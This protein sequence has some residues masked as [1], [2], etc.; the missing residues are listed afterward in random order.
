MAKFMNAELCGIRDALT[1]GHC[2]CTFK[3]SDSQAWKVKYEKKTVY[4]SDACRHAAMR[5]LHS[6]PLPN[7]GPC[8]TC[9]KPFFSRLNKKFCS[10]DCYIKSPQFKELAHSAKP[11]TA[12]AR[13]RG[14]QKLLKGGMVYC[15]ECGVEFYGKRSDSRKF[16]SSICYWSFM[17]KRFDRWIANPEGVALPQCY[18]E[19][20][21][22]E[23]LACLVEGCKWFGHHLTLHMNMA[24]GVR[25]D[26][27]KRAAGFNLNT[28]VIAKPLAELMQSRPLQGV[29]A[30]GQN[31][32]PLPSDRGPYLRYK[33]LEACEHHKKAAA[34][35]SETPG[36]D[37]V[38]Q[39]CGIVFQ[40]RTACGRQL[41]HSI[42]CRETF[43]ASKRKKPPAMRERDG[44]GRYV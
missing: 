32:L 3:G 23:E 1:C 7:C 24:H 39:G 19:F 22:Q 38:C 2:D 12:E 41:F 8:P 21:D 27:F 42:E 26:E 33:S 18:D 25:S 6:K 4:C 17:A 35:A 29:A 30:T 40:Q 16:C 11:M 36:P 44:M 28:G 10:L 5:N 15:M 9:G 37:R 43:Y 31:F 13:E 14:R 20:L 34:I